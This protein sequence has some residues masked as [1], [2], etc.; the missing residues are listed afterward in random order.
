MLDSVL[1]RVLYQGEAGQESTAGTYATPDG[2]QRAK[3]DFIGMGKTRVRIH[4]VKA[5]W[6][7]DMQRLRVFRHLGTVKGNFD[8]DRRVPHN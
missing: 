2:A 1:Y 4:K 7:G 8:A 5:P 6:V 3:Q